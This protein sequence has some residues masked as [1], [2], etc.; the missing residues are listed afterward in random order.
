MLV[1]R[2][3]RCALAKCMLRSATSASGVYD[4]E[5]RLS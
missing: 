3:S 2:I 5:L 1:I 4:N